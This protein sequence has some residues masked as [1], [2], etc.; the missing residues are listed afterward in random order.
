MALV[1]LPTSPKP[2]AVR[3]SAIDFGGTLSGA[4]G[5]T[6]QRINRL[7]NR[8]RLEVDLPPMTVADARVWAAALS[9]GLRN[10]VS[11]LVPQPDTPTGAAGSVLI[12]GASQAGDSIVVDGGT[13]GYQVKAGQ[14]LNVTTSGSAYLYM[15][16]A[17]SRLGASGDG[18]IEIEPPLR[19][20][21]ADNDPVNLSAP[22]I[23][24]LLQTG[25]GW[26]IDVSRL[27]R[28]F[29]FTIEEAR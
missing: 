2:R 18:T 16:Q 29:S 12:N 14:W 25:P 8:W 19:A 28:G 11:L 7:G 27:V 4:V 20:V 17:S 21:P 5:G 1:E 15:A 9:R 22:V 6:A 13:P 24:G 3:W 26:E 23:E 10:G